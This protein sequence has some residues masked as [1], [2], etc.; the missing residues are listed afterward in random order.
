MIPAR[1][2]ST[3][4]SNKNLRM[5]DGKPLIS[6][7]LDAV[8]A[9]G[10]FD[11]GSIYINSEAEIFKSV[12]DSHGVR[13][14][15]RDP[16]LSSN[17]ATNDDFALDFIEKVQPDILFQFLPTSPFI[18]GDDVTNFV[19]RM[20]EG[21]LDTLISVKSEKIECIFLEAPINFDQKKQTPPSQFLTPVQAYAC[22][23]MAW[24]CNPFIKNMEKHNAA[25]HGGDGNTG[26]FELC[27][28]ATVDIDT[29]ADF[30]LAE[31]VNAS[32]AFPDQAPTYY[33]PEIDPFVNY[34]VHV[35]EILDN[36][37]IEGR[38]FD[39]ENRTIVNA[40]EIISETDSGS[41][42][43]RVVNTE[44]NSCC[45]ISQQPGQG[46]RR[47]FHPSWNE[48]W[49]IVD[50][51]WDFEIADQHFAIKKDDIVFIPKNTWHK[52]TAIGNKPAVRLAVSREDV[53]HGYDTRK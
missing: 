8:I 24:R 20:I 53:K 38:N 11:K 47:H 3:R 43:R 28:F 30:R 18:T 26:F 21:N 42:I 33:Q 40:A 16:W 25:Y 5:I 17:E 44:N 14:Y 37:G 49:Y 51:E 13:F 7:I 34:E 9:S 32:M 22:G 46:N 23:M 36:D 6:F 12:A 29:E 45:L 27:G 31:A 52:I 2:G 19:N 41:W 48:W 35:P 15:E 50:G 39:L 1:L 10:I 4:V